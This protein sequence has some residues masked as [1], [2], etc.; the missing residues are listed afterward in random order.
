MIIDEVVFT[1]LGTLAYDDWNGTFT[2]NVPSDGTVI[3]NLLF[4][5]G[6]N[7]S[8]VPLPTTLPLLAVGLILLGVA[9]RR[10]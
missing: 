4:N 6:G 1:V 2:V 5:A 3:V 7:A 9:R 8:Q 10:A